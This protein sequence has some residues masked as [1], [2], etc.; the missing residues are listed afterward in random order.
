MREWE[1]ETQGDVGGPGKI[2]I[3]NTG[4]GIKDLHCFQNQAYSF[5]DQSKEQA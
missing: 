1:L 2:G 5:I 3:S 4:Q